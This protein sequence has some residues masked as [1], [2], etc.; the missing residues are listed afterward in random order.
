MKIAENEINAT[1]TKNGPTVHTDKNDHTG[2]NDYVI[3]IEPKTEDID[4]FK[5]DTD[6]NDFLYDELSNDTKEIDI[7][8]NHDNKEHTNE[9]FSKVTVNEEFSKDDS[10]ISKVSNKKKQSVKKTKSKNS[11]RSNKIV[12]PKAVLKKRVKDGKIKTVVKKE[13]G[14]GKKEEN[15]TK[16]DA[17]AQFKV[18]LLSFE[19]QLAEIEKR[20]ESPNFKYSRYKCDKCFKGFSSVPTYESHMEKHTNVSICRYV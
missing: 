12:K 4:A 13:K 2:E 9:I 8:T 15:G 14:S 10:K 20:R 7:K 1:T 17:L 16:G 18:T 5:S 3:D 19:E 11:S 6:D